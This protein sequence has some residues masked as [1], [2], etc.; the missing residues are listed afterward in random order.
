VTCENCIFFDSWT[1]MNI[2]GECRVNPPKSSILSTDRLVYPKVRREN[3]KCT[4]F[5]PRL[6]QMKME[7][8]DAS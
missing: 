3:Q 7:L 8:P 4:K 1:E 2:G 6:G 5:V